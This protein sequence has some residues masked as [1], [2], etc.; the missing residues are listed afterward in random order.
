MAK[1]SST[2]RDRVYHAIDR[3]K[4]AALQDR[5]SIFTPGKPVWDEATV[6]DLYDRFVRHADESKGSFLEKLKGQLGGAPPVTIQLAGELM[7]IHLVGGNSTSGDKKRKIIGTVLEWSPDP[8]AVPA[9]LNR[10][11]AEGFAA[12]GMGFKIHRPFHLQYLL[13]FVKGWW[14]LDEASRAGSLED[15]WE[16]KRIA[17]QAQVSYS[18]S[19]V[20]MLLHYVHPDAFESIMSQEHKWQIAEAFADLVEE[21][22]DDVDRRLCEIREKLQAT[23]GKGFSFYGPSLRQRWPR[24]NDPWAEFVNVAKI[25]RSGAEFDKWEHDVKLEFAA[26]TEPTIDSV[27]RSPGLETAEALHKALKPPKQVIVRWQDVDSFMKWFHKTPLVASRS[28]AHVMDPSPTTIDRITAFLD[29]IPNDV[30]KSPGNRTTLASL[31]LFVSDPEQFVPYRTTVFEWACKRVGYAPSQSEDEGARYEHALGFTD[32]VVEQCARRGFAFRNRLD[33]QGVLWWMAKASPGKTPKGITEEDWQV[34]LNYR[35]GVPPE[36]SGNGN[37]PGPSPPPVDKNPIGQLLLARKN[38]VLYGPPGTGKT[39]KSLELAAVWSDWQGED[40]VWQVTFHPTFAYEDFIEGFRP[41]ADGRFELRKGVFVEICEAAEQN[42]QRNYL[43][44]IDEIN[45]GDVARLF[46]ELITLI[47]ADKRHKGARRKLPYSQQELWVPP[48]LH[49]L[50]TMNTADRSIS[51]LDIA[52]RRRFCFVEYMPDGEVVRRSDEH[53]HDAGGVSLADLME[54]INR[55]LVA[56]GIDWDRT[57]GHSYFLV[58]KENGDPLAAIR[59]RFVYDVIPLVQEYCYADRSMMHKIL[60]KLIS[61]G[62]EVNTQ[63]IEDDSQFASALKALVTRNDPF[64]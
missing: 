16:F 5:D 44:I 42:P 45:R 15:P 41:N 3:F 47:E 49:L 8:V 22:T 31:F 55:R 23:E 21:E 39:Y 6:D 36:L 57:I 61:D 4:Q 20:Q 29:A 27:L 59:Q 9:E 52:I 50:G 64:A 11:L 38:V 1:H 32:E 12:E 40:A 43:L 62:G 18:Q 63:V 51:L 10:A 56:V 54:E 26:Q 34:V 19:Q 17:L 25:V 7:F 14:Q 33:A 2:K 37:G 24:E 53:Y 30:V 35:Q 48:N 13:E 46:G 60:G 28:L 58:P